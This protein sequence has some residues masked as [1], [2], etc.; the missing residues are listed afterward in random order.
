M[1]SVRDLD[2]TFCS[3]LSFE[4][5][6]LKSISQA[7]KI[8]GFVMRSFK[9]FKNIRTLRLLY[10]ALVRPRLEYA[11]IVWSPFQGGLCTLIEGVQHRFMRRISFLTDKPMSY[12]DH[13]YD[14]MLIELRLATLENRRIFLDLL[15][16]FKLI[17]GSITC[18]DLL[19]RIGLHCPAR[20]L[21]NSFVFHVEIH[22]TNY[23]NFKPLNRTCLSVNK[24]FDRVDFFQSSLSSF[25]RSLMSSVG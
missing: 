16:L 14:N 6:I 20:S 24:L 25:R 1:T 17:G 2:V 5:H 21:R 18:S 15:F 11:S 9:Y 3:D 22:R 10:C 19:C 8:L 4:E 13:C 12:V 23:G 7:S